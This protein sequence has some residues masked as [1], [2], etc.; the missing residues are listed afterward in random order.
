MERK[1]EHTERV[2]KR[3]MVMI[4]VS[5]SKPIMSMMNFLCM[6]FCTFQF[7]IRDL[8]SLVSMWNKEK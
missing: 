7:L 3:G 5:V 2:G 8:I 4:G 6:S 1:V